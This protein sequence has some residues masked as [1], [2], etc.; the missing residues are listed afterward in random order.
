ML[1]KSWIIGRTGEPLLEF[2]FTY[3]MGG[4]I[5]ERPEP[6]ALDGGEAF[7]ELGGRQ[8]GGEEE[9]RVFHEDG[10]FLSPTSMA[11][12][13]QKN[14]INNDPMNSPGERDICQFPNMMVGTTA[15]KKQY[16]TS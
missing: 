14:G 15:E 13:M 12:S 16:K 11:I 6:V 7:L 1:G 8:V 4:S 2:P 3:R 10:G 5:G 9:G